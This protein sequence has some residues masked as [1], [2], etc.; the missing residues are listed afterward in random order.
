MV[1]GVSNQE[2][3]HVVG[4][5]SKQQGKKQR[6]RG[7][8]KLDF[9]RAGKSNP[10]K[11]VENQFGEKEDCNNNEKKHRGSGRGRHLKQLGSA[12][13]SN[14]WRE[15][16]GGNIGQQNDFNN[17]DKEMG[18][19]IPTPPLEFNEKILL[20][21]EEKN[22]SFSDI[23]QDAEGLGELAN[24]VKEIVL[25][26]PKISES[27]LRQKLRNTD[28][29]VE[30]VDFTNL[31]FRMSE[32]GEVELEK[33]CHGSI[34][35]SPSLRTLREAKARE[36]PEHMIASSICRTIP[37][38]QL[39]GH[40]KEGSTISI[41]VTEVK[42]PGRFWF[43][44]HEFTE[45]PVYFEAAQS[46]MDRMQK[47]YAEEGDKWRVE[48]VLDCQPGTVLAAQY[49]IGKVKE[50]FHRVIVKQE[51][52]LRRLKLFYIDHGTTAE[53]KLKHVRFLPAEFGQLPGQAMEAQ[54]WGVE[55]VGQESRWPPGA[56]QKFFKLVNE[57][58]VG[59]LLA[60]IMEG[61][62]RRRSKVERNSNLL[63]IHHGLSLSLTRI[64]LGPKGTDIAKV[65]VAEG[66]ARWED[67]VKAEGKSVSSVSPPTTATSSVATSE[68]PPCP[69]NLDAQEL[70][71]REESLRA[72]L[73][74]LCIGMGVRKMK[75]GFDH[76]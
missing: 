41:V 35:V 12:G 52:G 67:E 4:M 43:N 44:L 29:I 16:V 39:P 21:S 57:A 9:G 25:S 58:D 32:A 7:R 51:A 75:L 56:T 36:G 60:R 31:L 28:S 6:G 33:A 11:E 3:K 47:F 8:G 37:T 69:E 74:K 27:S 70:S 40:L 38:Q 49:S 76:T 17:K 48:S 19:R 14:L 15:E 24:K 18:W 68:F 20:D 42:S 34:C 59:S 55:Q 46:L 2:T 26:E 63:K 65:L 50:G 61:V 64:N 53:Q 72:K 54:L 45:T 13:W 1:S 62:T 66:L 5:V 30:A 73:D 10:V 22:N 23:A 71:L